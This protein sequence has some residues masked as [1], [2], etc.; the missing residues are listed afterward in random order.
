V[1][2]KAPLQD[3]FSERVG[4]GRTRVEKQGRQAVARMHDERARSNVKIDSGKIR[5][6]ACPTFGFCK[7][8]PA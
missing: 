2:E 6:I 1:S 3:Q 8:D 5:V 7:N 4:A